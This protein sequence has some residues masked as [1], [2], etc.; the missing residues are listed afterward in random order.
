MTVDFDIKG[1]VIALT[2][3]RTLS[4]KFACD[5]PAH[6]RSRPL[7]ALVSKQPNSSLPKDA[8]SRLLT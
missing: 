6:N 8:S 1:K 3:V 7:Q 2:G 5:I 4:R